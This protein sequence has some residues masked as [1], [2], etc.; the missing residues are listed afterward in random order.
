MHQDEFESGDTKGAYS[1][2]LISCEER[3]HERL[4]FLGTSARHNLRV[5]WINIFTWA[6]LRKKKQKKK[7]LLT[8]A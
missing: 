8:V 2:L 5:F 3:D 4:F 7:H 1:Y 6:K